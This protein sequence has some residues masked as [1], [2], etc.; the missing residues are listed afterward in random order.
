MKQLIIFGTGVNWNRLKKVI[1]YGETEIIAFSDNNKEKWN[2]IIDG[3]KVIPPAEILRHSFDYIVIA[4]QYYDEI[5][6]QLSELGVEVEK[7]LSFLSG[8]ILSFAGRETLSIYNAEVLRQER[9]VVNKMVRLKR[10]RLIDINDGDYVRFSALELA[11]HEI[12]SKNLE[13]NVAEVGVYQGAFARKLNSL[14]KDRLLY[15]LDTFE[16]FERND[17]LYE[18]KGHFS[19]PKNSAFS[20]TS[21]PRVLN[22]MKYPEQCIICKG[23][24]PESAEEIEDIFVFVSL[25]ADLYNPTYEGL[26]YFY[27]LLVKG[28]YIFVHDYNNDEYTGVK[29]AVRQFCEESSIGYVPVGDMCGTVIITK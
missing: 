26:K 4:S 15:L 18:E 21:I 13:G 6:L 25:D 16:G 1:D 10:S 22:N 20:D 3:I 9:L 8:D 27:P 7:V 29:E 11:A 23:H 28:G 14:F 24:F 2:R 19:S 12:Y 17:I 5:K